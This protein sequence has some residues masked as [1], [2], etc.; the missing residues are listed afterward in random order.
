M[1]IVQNFNPPLKICNH[2]CDDI[3]IIEKKE[4]DE[5]INDVLCT[6]EYIGSRQIEEN[7]KHYWKEYLLVIMVMSLKFLNWRQS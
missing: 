7:W 2:N 6:L 4:W 5:E 1:K 3:Q